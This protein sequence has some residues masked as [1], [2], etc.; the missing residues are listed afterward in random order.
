MPMSKTGKKMM[1]SMKDT[2]GKEKGK[3][4]FYAMENQG[5]VPGMAEGGMSKPMGY[6]KGGLTKS[7]G[8]LD[9]GIKKCKNG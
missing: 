7:T 9:T 1:K 5:R 4:V 3:D 2:Y 8:T 6:A